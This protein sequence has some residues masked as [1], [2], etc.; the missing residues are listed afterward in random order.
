MAP[1]QDVISQDRLHSKY[2]YEMIDSIGSLVL[3]QLS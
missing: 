3:E 1:L 2:S